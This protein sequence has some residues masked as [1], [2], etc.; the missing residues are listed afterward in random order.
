MVE[1]WKTR[2]IRSEILTIN[3]HEIEVVKNFKYLG[4]VI[5]NA[6]DETEE[7]KAAILTANKAYYSLQTIFMSK[8]IHHNNKIRI[9]KTLIRAVLC[10]GNVT[11]TLT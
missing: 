1:K 9:Y 2:R 8:R 6:N 4:A 5:N 7:I 3:D 10:Y 11:S